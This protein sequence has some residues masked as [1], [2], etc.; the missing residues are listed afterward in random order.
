MPPGFFEGGQPRVANL[1]F[2]F[3]LPAEW[4][5]KV[6]ALPAILRPKNARLARRIQR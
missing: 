1:A 4:V 2:Q 5:G 6:L 3:G